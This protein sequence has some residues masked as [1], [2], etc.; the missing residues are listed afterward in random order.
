MF[1]VLC[2][3]VPTLLC[4]WYI[5]TFGVNVVC[6]DE[7]AFFP[8][9][10]QWNEGSFN[11][12]ALFSLSYNDHRAFFPI[13]YLISIAPPL[14]Y[15]EIAI[16]Y[17]CLP[18]LVG[19]ATVA[20]L[21]ADKRLA[22][23]PFRRVILLVMAFFMLDLKQWDNMIVNFSGST[24]APPFFYAISVYLLDTLSTRLEWRLPAALI[25]AFCATF[26]SASGLLSFPLGLLQVGGES[27][28]KRKE[29]T[30]GKAFIRPIVWSLSSLV[31]IAYYF[32]TFPGVR[33]SFAGTP[34]FEYMKNNPLDALQIF[35]ACLANPLAGESFTAFASGVALI[36]LVALLGWMVLSGKWQ[37][38]R[39][40]FAPLSLM[41]FGLAT[42]CLIFV[43]RSGMGILGV[44]APRYASLTNLGIVG[45][46][47]FIATLESI[48]RE[49]RLML[50]AVITYAMFASSASSAFA[51]LISGEIVRDMRINAAA[52]L[53]N[54]K[55]APLQDLI[56][57]NPFPGIIRMWAPYLESHKYNV[58]ETDKVSLT[59]ITETKEPPIFEVEKISVSTPAEAFD[60]APDLKP[61]NAVKI[62]GFA[63][64]L[65]NRTPS[66]RVLVEV[67]GK[68]RFITAYGLTRRDVCA[69]YRRNAYLRSGFQLGLRSHLFTKGEH[70]VRLI[71]ISPDGKTY[72]HTWPVGQFKI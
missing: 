30:P 59:G 68:Q 56:H 27:W 50:I 37:M 61:E 17:L 45:L 42:S 14:N 58:F 4:I 43:G 23:I 41:G 22:K 48:R 40:S 10:K 49:T 60:D 69:R 51:S 39:Q 31:V 66:Q 26:S 46:L 33:K 63:F 72:F 70:T 62:R 1:I 6:A 52:A 55:V 25:S 2:L 57:V 65:K 18:I 24:V 11:W 34:S 29:E 19:T 15:N 44:L 71:I 5:Q 38:T 54:Y 12:Y 32:A 9:L 53:Y 28:L 20:L 7:W 47:L 67:D 35:L 64:D 8:F 16:E 13:L 21:L 3:L 36:C